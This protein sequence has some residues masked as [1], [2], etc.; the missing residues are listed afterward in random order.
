IHAGI[1]QLCVN[2]PAY[3]EINKE[4]EV[5]LLIDDLSPENIALHLNR[6]LQDE[7]LYRHLQQNCLRASQVYC[8][9]N[10]EK[11]LVEF[12]RKIEDEK[13]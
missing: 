1:P 9:Q 2:Y 10:E 4:F 11:K 12:Y 7:D 5:A 6:L 3:E 13:S 8:W